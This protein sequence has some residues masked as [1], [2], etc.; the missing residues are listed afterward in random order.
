[1]GV[2][3]CT[4]TRCHRACAYGSPLY[5]IRTERPGSESQLCQWGGLS[6]RR[7]G[8]RHRLPD[9]LQSTLRKYVVEP[10]PPEYLTPVP[11]GVCCYYNNPQG[12]VTFIG[13]DRLWSG[14]VSAEWKRF[15]TLSSNWPGN[16]V[17]MAI[18]RSPDCYA[19]RAG[20]SMTSGSSVSGDARGS[21]S[22]ASSPGAV[23]FGWPTDHVSGSGNGSTSHAGAKA[24]LKLTF[25]LDHS[26]GANHS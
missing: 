8:G 17:A 6:K 22:P 18:A 16:T 23:G 19:R 15:A 4:P 1:M 25:Q 5:W 13:A 9:G 14:H 10:P 2:A 26:V 3:R 20:R 12:A 7:S 11:N 24:N 21:K